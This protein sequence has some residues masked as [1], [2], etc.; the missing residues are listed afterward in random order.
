[1]FHNDHATSVP[2]MPAPKTVV[3]EAETF[4]TIGNAATGLPATTLTADWVNTV[5]N[6]LLNVV[7]AGKL[8]PSKTNNTQLL[9]GIRNLINAAID[10]L[11]G[12][13][14]YVPNTRKITT[15]APLQG[16]GDLTADRNLT[17]AK[18]T[19]TDYGVVALATVAEA[20]AGGNTE[21]AVTPAGLSAA[22]AGLTPSGGGPTSSGDFFPGMIVPFKGSF[23]GNYPINS[24]TGTADTSWALCNGSNG[25]PNLVGSFILGGT[26]YGST[27]GSSTH[28]HTASSSSTGNASGGS[29]GATT[30][31]ASQMPSHGH[32][33]NQGEL[34]M[35]KGDGRAGSE[36]I[37]WS[38]TASKT[39]TTAAVGS[40]GSHT[41]SLSNLSVSV[42]TN[43]TV[44][45]ASNLPPYY[46][47]AYI[48]K[49]N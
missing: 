9:Q 39:S 37:W 8:T 12:G 16:G 11:E 13:E 25:T 34:N 4:A 48:M 28:S 30:L 24:R 43:T 18:A 20:K 3:S 29:V 21:K 27:G 17:I 2:T 19:T 45:S 26:S 14:E 10:G 7:R 23:S 22:L 41:H 36:Y 1:M 44:N 15:S 33:Y 49:I 46:T 5:Q 47:L 32:T 38:R 42:T 31:T 35:E 40:G 6:E